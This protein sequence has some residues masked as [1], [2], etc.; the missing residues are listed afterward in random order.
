MNEPVRI[1]VVD[2]DPDMLRGT[3]R[4]LEKAGYTVDRAASGEE[5]LQAAQNHPPDL[6]L[7]DHDLP[8]IKVS[9]SAAV[10]SRIRP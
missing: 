5:A 2:D 9:K 10:S 8:G 7:L 3:A 6:L 1:L 4:L